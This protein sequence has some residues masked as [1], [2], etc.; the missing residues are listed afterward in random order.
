[1]CVTPENPSIGKKIKVRLYAAES[2]LDDITDVRIRTT[3]DNEEY[4]AKTAITKRMNGYAVFS[5]EIP[6]LIEHDHLTL[7][8]GELLSWRVTKLTL[9]PTAEQRAENTR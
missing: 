8:V 1:L 3:C 5:G 2:L 9:K 6:F 7:F 4:P